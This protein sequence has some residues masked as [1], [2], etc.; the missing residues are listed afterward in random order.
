MKNKCE[1]IKDCRIK[2]VLDHSENVFDAF[3][4]VFKVF[5]FI[6]FFSPNKCFIIITKRFF[7]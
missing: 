7:F 3:Y 4:L 2:T 1:F 6:F 5:T